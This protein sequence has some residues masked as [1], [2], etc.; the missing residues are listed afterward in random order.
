VSTLARRTL[1]EDASKRAQ[2]IAERLRAITG[3]Q[4]VLVMCWACGCTYGEASDGYRIGSDGL[5]YCASEDDCN[6]RA[7][8]AGLVLVLG[9]PGTGDAS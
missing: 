5:P 4:N 1:P 9:E 3:R 7:A 8:R 6:E 2:L